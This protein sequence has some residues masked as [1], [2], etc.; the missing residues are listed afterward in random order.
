MINKYQHLYEKIKRIKIRIKRYQLLSEKMEEIKIEQ[1]IEKRTTLSRTSTI[2]PSMAGRTIIIHNGKE[3]IPVPVYIIESMIGYKFGETPVYNP[4]FNLS[5]K[6]KLWR[7]RATK[8]DT[9]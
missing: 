4:I 8:S 1:E 7:I 6:Y 2:T 5:K 9:F 3:H